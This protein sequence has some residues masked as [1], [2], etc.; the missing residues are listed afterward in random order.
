MLGQLIPEVG[1]ISARCR[2][3]AQGL[4]RAFMGSIYLKVGVGGVSTCP[5]TFSPEL[6]VHPSQAAGLAS[7][8]LCLQ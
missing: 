4:R 5:L 7:L 1:D 8:C 2:P 3:E 6:K